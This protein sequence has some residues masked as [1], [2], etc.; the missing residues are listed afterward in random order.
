[1]RADRR[2]GN[3]AKNGQRK[4]R[5][6]G[7][8]SR[9][10]APSAAS[11]TVPHRRRGV[12]AHRRR[13]GARAC[14][15]RSTRVKS[16]LEVDRPAGMDVVAAQEEQSGP[17]HRRRPRPSSTASWRPGRSRGARGRGSRDFTSTSSNALGADPHQHVGPDAGAGVLEGGLEDRRHRSGRRAAGRSPPRRP[18]T[19]LPP[20]TSTPPGKRPRASDADLAPRCAPAPR[21]RARRDRAARARSTRGRAVSRT[22]DRRRT[23]LSRAWAPRRH[24]PGNGPRDPS[25]QAARRRGEVEKKFATAALR[26]SRLPETSGK[27]C[28]TRWPLAPSRSERRGIEAAGCA[29]EGWSMSEVAV[30][31]VRKTRSRRVRWRRSLR[32]RPRGAGARQAVLSLPLQV[33]LASRGRGARAPADRRSGAARRQPLRRPALRRRDDLARGRGGAPGA[34]HRAHALR[35]VRDRPPGIGSLFSRLG[36]VEASTTTARRC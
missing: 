35:E 6:S 23:G 16:R 34:S 11:S 15:V 24:R 3:G 28:A 5:G 13:Y 29:V 7:R 33:L 30:S 10:S 14:S 12:A 32:L 20:S 21:G 36:G 9:R 19:L 27:T 17:R 31:G 25:R 18:P 1:M 8:R 4:G 22:G 2:R 26:H